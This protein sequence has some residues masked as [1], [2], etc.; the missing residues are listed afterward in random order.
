MEELLRKILA[1]QLAQLSLLQSIAA[2]IA[3]QTRFEVGGHDKTAQWDEAR[4]AIETA[5]K[6]LP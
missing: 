2:N 6:H 5:L 3:E 4:K 1:A